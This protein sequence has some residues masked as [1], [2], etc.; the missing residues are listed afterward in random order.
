MLTNN[1]GQV[2]VVGPNAFLNVGG[3]GNGGTLTLPEGLTNLANGFYQLANGTLGETIGAMGFL[4]FAVN[5]GLVMLDGTL[6]IMLDTGFNPP[7]GTTYD[8]PT[9]DPGMLSGTFSKIIQ[10]PF[11]NETEYWVLNYNNAGGYVS[12]EAEPVPEPS[13]FLMVG[14]GLLSLA[15][16]IRRRLLK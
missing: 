11:N 14:A 5:G 4:I 8:F 13:S 15:Y 2:N 7:V 3:I 1:G 10:Q 9:F 16:G 6:D 12:L